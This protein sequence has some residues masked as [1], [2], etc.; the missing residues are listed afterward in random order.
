MACDLCGKRG[1]YLNDLR[2]CYKTD[3]VQQIC[4]ECMREV[5]EQHRKTQKWAFALLER[6][7]K[8][9]LTEKFKAKQGEQA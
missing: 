1:C 4:D 2:D 3:E 7:M 8:R 5:N 9:F 6:F